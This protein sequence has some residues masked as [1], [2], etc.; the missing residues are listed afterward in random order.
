MKRIAYFAAFVLL[1]FGTAALSAAE[2]PPQTELAFNL[3]R[4]IVKNNANE[5]VT[6]SPYGV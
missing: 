4:T 3:Y 2:P 1:T 6:V 5:N